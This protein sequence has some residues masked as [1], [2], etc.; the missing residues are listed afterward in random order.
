ETVQHSGS[1]WGS[2]VRDRDVNRDHPTIYHSDVS[3]PAE[4]NRDPP[5]CDFF[6][7]KTKAT[8]TRSCA[9]RLG[10]IWA[11]THN[12]MRQCPLWGDSGHYSDI[13]ERPL[14]P[15]AFGVIIEGPIRGA[16]NQNVAFV[17]LGQHSRRRTSAR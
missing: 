7:K 12:F 4:W 17:R 13:A 5:I 2:A 11:C 6:S 10:G 16:T 8:W 9:Q 14:S 1:V 15:L 3:G